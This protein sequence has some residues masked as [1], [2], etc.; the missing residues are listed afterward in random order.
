MKRISKLRLSAL[1][2]VIGVFYMTALQ[3][4]AAQSNQL[5]ERMLSSAERDATIGE[6]RQKRLLFPIQGVDPET[7]KGSFYEARGGSLHHA[8]D[9]LAPRNTPV[10]A[11]SDGTIAKL[12]LSKA[13]GN[14]IYEI[15][16]SGKY[17]YYYAHLQRYAATLKEGDRVHRG[18]TIGFVGTSG[19][20]PVNT[21]HLHFSV[22]KLEHP[23]IWWPGMSV[24][25][26]DVFRGTQISGGRMPAQ[27]LS[28]GEVPNLPSSKPYRGDG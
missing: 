11:V 5:P 25:P 26:F 4:F 3:S 16:P 14:T 19:N 28:P 1:L 15:D 7:I 20:A 17:S 8:S 12:W 21:P 22:S 27:T 10:L 23:G 6:L 13:G 2:S 24:D 18:Q 9:I